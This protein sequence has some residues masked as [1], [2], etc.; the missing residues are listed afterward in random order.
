[1]PWNR[2]GTTTLSSTGSPITVSGFG[3]STFIQE[4]HHGIAYGSY[5]S[6]LRLNNDSGTKYANRRR[7]NGTNENSGTNR[8]FIENVYG[9]DTLMISFMGDIDGEEKMIINL[10]G[11]SGSSGAG[12][13]PNRLQLIGKYVPSPTARITQVNRFD[14][15]GG[16][17]GIDT[18][19]T[20]LGSDVTLSALATN[21]QVGSRYEETDTRKIYF[22]IDS[23]Y[24]TDKWFEAG[25]VPY[26]GG[27]G[28]FGGGLNTSSS[29]ED[30]I[31]YITIATTGNATDFGNLSQARYGLGAMANK[32]RTLFAGGSTGGGG[33]QTTIDFITPA[34]LGNATDF[35]DISNDTTKTYGVMCLSSETRGIIGGGESGYSNRIDYVTIAS[36]G[37]S[38]T[39][40]TLD[41]GK[42]GATTSDGTR[43]VFMGGEGRTPTM[44]YI[45]IASTGN[46]TDFGD[47]RVTLYGG[48][49]G[50]ATD[51]T[52]GVFTTGD[53]YSANVEKITIQTT[54]NSTNFGNMS[55][56]R[57]NLGLASDK[58]RAIF[59]GGKTASGS[60]Y[61]NTI[62]YS[63][64]PTPSGNASDFG[65]LQVARQVL[66]GASDTGADRS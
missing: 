62:E 11:F 13:A 61:T 16:A 8:T 53:S 25:T 19:L 30:T 28:V 47:L 29:A 43:G 1:M 64:I 12:N 45:T 32:T 44:D 40:G 2:L 6:S 54:G 34:T 27:R 21:V 36:A 49:H 57:S 31:D 18:N 9:G 17:H 23:D 59:A 39:F 51:G 4:L 66:A 50:L 46:A 65:D 15:E 55:T 48:S 52:I 14:S 58:T 42:Q 33:N 7:T 24:V 22:R 20:V 5:G 35:G 63:A 60:N 10:G 38:T 26:A 41:D 56:G 3:A 37:N